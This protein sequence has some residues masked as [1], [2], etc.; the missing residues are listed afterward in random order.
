MKRAYVPSRTTIHCRALNERDR[1]ISDDEDAEF[2]CKPL[3]RVC[4]RACQPGIRDEDGI[5]SARRVES[6]ATVRD[7]H[8]HVQHLM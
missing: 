4:E 3:E 7:E 1:R 6:R 8:G 5:R 2:L